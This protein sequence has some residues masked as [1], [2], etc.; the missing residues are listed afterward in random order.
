[1][2]TALS[3]V[4]S[5]DTIGRVCFKELKA[6]WTRTKKCH[7]FISRRRTSSF[8][9]PL[10]VTYYFVLPFSDG[11]C[12]KWG[13]SPSFLVR[14]KSSLFPGAVSSWEDQ[15]QPLGNTQLGRGEFSLVSSFVLLEVSSAPNKIPLCVFVAVY[16]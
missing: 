16:R 4:P 3:S 10:I 9:I 6:G 13:I 2:F 8:N 5:S 11:M 7:K 1:M 15:R 12:L 14:H